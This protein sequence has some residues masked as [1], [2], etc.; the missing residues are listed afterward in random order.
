MEASLGKMDEEVGEKGVDAS[1][2]T[3]GSMAVV[4]VVG[5]EE[6]VVASRGDS[7]TVL[8]RGDVVVPLSVDHKPD[9]PD[10]KERVEVAGGRVTDWNGSCVLGVLATSRSIG[11]Y[12]LKQNV[13]AEPE[14][15]VVRRC[16]NGHI[17]RRFPKELRG[18]N[19]AEVA[20]VLAE[21]AVAQGSQDNISV[22][23]IELKKPN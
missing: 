4:A 17:K 22:I 13:M 21:L 9:R 11:D 6:V 23:V 3:A 10:E 19:A 18:S 8:C 12:Y 20:A 1:M 5:K 16:L 14:V 15:T 7:R 2:R